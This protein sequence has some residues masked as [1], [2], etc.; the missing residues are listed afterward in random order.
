LQAESSTA[1]AGGCKAK[2]DAARSKTGW[3]A[4]NNSSCAETWL[5]VVTKADHADVFDSDEALVRLLGVVDTLPKARL[6]LG[7][8]AKGYEETGGPAPACRE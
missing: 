1:S 7:R 4:T 5:Y 8:R 3:F 2:L 6:I